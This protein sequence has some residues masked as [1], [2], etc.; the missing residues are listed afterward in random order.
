MKIAVFGIRGIPDTYS[1]YETFCSV[2]LPELVARGHDVTLYCRGGRGRLADYQG[3]RRESLPSLA[4]KQLD[5]LTH[6]F[7]AAAVARRGDYD[8]ALAFNV[9]NAPAMALFAGGRT[10]T[11]LNVDGQEWKRGKWG[12]VG[13][14]VFRVCARVAPH[15]ADVLVTD[16]DEMKRIYDRE[17][18]APSEVVPYCAPKL[19]DDSVDEIAEKQVLSDHELSR[20]DYFIT[21]GR[22]VPENNI[23]SIVRSYLASGE[24]RPIAV[25]GAANYRSPVSIEL[26]R[27]AGLHPNVRLLGHIDDRHDFGV[28]LRNASMYFH[29]HSVGGIN[30]SLLEAMGV[31]ARIAAYDTPFN[32]EGLGDTGT[33]FGDPERSVAD[34]IVDL[35]NAA[36]DTALREAARERAFGEFS[37][38]R[39]CSRYEDL[40]RQTVEAG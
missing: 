23:D 4:T 17:F 27:L 7:A 12:T 14:K 30:P 10:A 39:I 29:G 6:S 28:L 37:V 11:V 8:V 13:R 3:V 33:Y 20:R 21:G 19:L 25:L 18:G 32:R 26:E 38:D 34:S 40:L 31:G 1:G 35:D 5:T 16:C 22:L 15:T 36:A 24:E 2:L 9:A